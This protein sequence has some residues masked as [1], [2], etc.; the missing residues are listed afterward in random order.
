VTVSV[1]FVRD[2]RLT[3]LEDYAHTKLCHPGAARGRLLAMNV[4]L[5]KELEQLVN[6]KVKSG[7]YQT[8]SEVVR[9]GLRLLDERDRLYQLR[10]KDLRKDIKKGA[11][12]L[13]RGEGRPLDVAAMKARLRADVAAK[14]RRGAK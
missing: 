7:L 12:Q 3:R 8:A 10:L 5:T 14:S 2:G 6:Q 9:E 13:D 1:L 11:D 4:S